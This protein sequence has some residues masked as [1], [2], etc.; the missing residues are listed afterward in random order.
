M[1]TTVFVG[2]S[3]DG[4]LARRDGTF[5][6]LFGGGVDSGADNGYD[7]FIVTVDALLMGRHTFDVVRAFEK[8]PYGDKPVFVLSSKPLAPAAQP[9]ERLDGEPS[10]VLK[11][12]EAKGIGHVYVD[13]GLTIQ[14]FLRAGLVDRMVITRLPVLIGEG[15]PL[16]GT[17]GKD[18]RLKHVSTRVIGDAAVQSIYEVVR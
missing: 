3:V 14:Q 6:F 18:V 4:F 9:V 16:F 1:K 12:L 8:W 15:I 7:E 10:E 13:G 11:A 5:D 17:L 2:I